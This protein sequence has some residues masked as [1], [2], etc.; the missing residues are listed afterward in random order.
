MTGATTTGASATTTTAAT[1]ATLTT[2]GAAAT[3]GGTENQASPLPLGARSGVLCFRPSQL[4]A[5]V[6]RPAVGKCTKRIQT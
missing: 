4:G 2:I 6:T 1:T 5:S 3:T